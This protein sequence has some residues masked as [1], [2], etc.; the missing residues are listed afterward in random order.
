MNTPPLHP[1]DWQRPLALGLAAAV[2]LVPANLLPVIHTQTAGQIRTDTIYSGVI[3]LWEHG[4][5]PLAAIVFIASFV[6]PIGKLVGLGWLL[7]AVRWG[8]RHPARL[9]RWYARLDL[10][11]RWSMLDVFLAAFLA[12]LVQFGALATVEPRPGL[13]A[14]AAAV[15]LTMLATRAFDPHRLWDRPQPLLPSSP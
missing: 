11:G 15:V 4:L 12:G 14:F 7:A 5:W 2:M 9:T 13:I 6:V 1:P 8:T 10:I 3:E